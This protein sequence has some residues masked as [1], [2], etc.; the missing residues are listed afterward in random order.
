M[1]VGSSAVSGIVDDTF[2]VVVE[3]V[4]IGRDSHGGRTTGDGSFE[5]TNRLGD[6]TGSVGNIDAS[7]VSLASALF[8][9][10]EV[11]V[12]IYDIVGLSIL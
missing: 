7:G 11:L 5:T 12:L 9:S 8:L 1:V 6:D 3:D 10:V 4:A 2:L